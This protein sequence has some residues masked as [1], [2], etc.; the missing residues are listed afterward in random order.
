MR[1]IIQA[2]NDIIDDD[3]YNQ[4]INSLTN[5]ETKTKE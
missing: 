3:K 4:I 5:K 2:H 1:N